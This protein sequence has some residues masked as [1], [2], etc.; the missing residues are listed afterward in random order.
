MDAWTDWVEAEHYLASTTWSPVQN[1]YIVDRNGWLLGATA[2]FMLLLLLLLRFCIN[3]FEI[4]MWTFSIGL[5]R[6]VPLR[7]KIRNCCPQQRY[8]QSRNKQMASEGI[9]AQLHVWFD[10][11]SNQVRRRSILVPTGFL[12]SGKATFQNFLSYTEQ[13]CRVVENETISN[14]LNLSEHL[15]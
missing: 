15:K 11:N 14:R 7:I 5:P 6:W 1:L 9:T 10:K 12:S 3:Y 8:S 2:A 13:S 4:F